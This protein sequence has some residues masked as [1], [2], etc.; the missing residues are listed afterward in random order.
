[1]DHWRNHFVN[2]AL[3]RKV[4]LAVRWADVAELWIAY[5]VTQ[6]LT[7]LR[8]LRAIDVDFARLNRDQELEEAFRPP[9]NRQAPL[10]AP[11]VPPPPPAEQGQGVW[12]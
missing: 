3:P 4:Y 5:K 1:M 10:L 12:V 7:R 2:Q 8:F 11:H 9:L 6:A